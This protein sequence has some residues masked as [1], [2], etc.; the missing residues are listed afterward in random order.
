MEKSHRYIR[1]TVRVALIWAVAGALLGV[2][3]ELLNDL[4]SDGLPF[5]SLVDVWPPLL[6]IAG[7]LVGAVVSS[8]LRLAGVRRLQ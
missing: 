1:S 2:L 5:A 3:V 4:L 7:F 8:V 6:A